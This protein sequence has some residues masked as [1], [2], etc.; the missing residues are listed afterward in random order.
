[1]RISLSPTQW[2]CQAHFGYLILVLQPRNYLSARSSTHLFPSSGTINC[3]ADGPVSENRCFLFLP[4]FL[5]ICGWRLILDSVISPWS[6]A[7]ISCFSSI[8][9][10]YACAFTLVS[11]NTKSSLITLLICVQTKT[12]LNT[13][14]FALWFVAFLSSQEI[15][16]YFLI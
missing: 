4:S 14:L 5:V 8:T 16:K 12:F 13:W 9:F 1:M 7:E 2:D 3:T 11:F 15:L 10:F 6:K